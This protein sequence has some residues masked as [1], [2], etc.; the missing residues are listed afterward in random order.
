MQKKTSRTLGFCAVLL[1]LAL[2]GVGS[3]VNIFVG[4]P[5]SKIG[6]QYTAE[7]HLKK[8]YGKTDYVLEG[9]SYSYKAGGYYAYLSSPS[10]VDGDF[11]LTISM[12]GELQSDD[13]QLR[14]EEKWNV[15]NRLFLEY[16][17]LVDTVL[18]SSSYPYA[19]SM[20]FGNLEFDLEL[21]EEEVEGALKRSELENNKRYDVS[22]L[23]AKNGSLV[24]YVD[25][26]EVTA[27]KAVEIL[28]E[29]KRL[30]DAEEIAF[31]SV[32]LI[33]RYPPYNEDKSYERPE[34]EVRLR[35]FLASDIY[36]ENMT[37]RVEQCIADTKAYYEEQNKDKK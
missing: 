34:G 5:L 11:T 37:A 6:A 18:T 1:V 36:E 20:G 7:K 8:Y 15:A 12:F 14:V 4:N 9:V 27:G 29:T 32:E 31:Y 23:G 35:D 17:D 30:M 33:L 21:G 3:V 25:S 26:D 22:A 28:L 16:R 19:L 24:L 13:Y 10:N 2:L